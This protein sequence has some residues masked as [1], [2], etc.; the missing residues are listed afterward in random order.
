MATAV[1]QLTSVAPTVRFEAFSKYF[2][3]YALVLVISW[4]G[5]MKFT[6]PEAQA[7]QPLLATSPFMSWLLRVFS[8]QGASNFIGVAE[9]TTALLLALRPFSAKIGLAGGVLAIGTFLTTLSFMLSLPHAA[10]WDQ[11]L[12]GFPALA[13]NGGFLVKDFVLLGAAV[14]CTSDA[15]ADLQ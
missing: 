4:I 12:G 6:G 2:V 1:Q 5:F 13:G 15:L 9:V 3:R 14:L 8:L 7:I 11:S 10:V